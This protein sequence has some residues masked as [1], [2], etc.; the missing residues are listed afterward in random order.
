MGGRLR[1]E[2]AGVATDLSLP[3]A[4]RLDKVVSGAIG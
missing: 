4:G 3:R 1:F 2:E